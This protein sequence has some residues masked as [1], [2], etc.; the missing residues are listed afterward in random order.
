M[1]YK[2]SLIVATLGRKTELELLLKSLV[3]QTISISLFEVI[4]VDQ[5]EG[6]L[7]DGLVEKYSGPLNL[8]CIKSKR[9]GLSH[10]RNI[11]IRESRGTYIG[12]PDDD[13]EY[14]P[15][16]LQT[17]EEEL[18]KLSQPDMIIGKVFNRKT[19]TYV[20]KKTPDQPLEI[21]RSNFY[22]VVSSITLFFKKEEHTFD[23]DFGIGEKYHSNED[24][25]LILNFLKS[26]KRVVYSPA[27][28]FD[29]PPYDTSNMSLDKLYKYGIGFGALC[30]KYLSMPLLFLMAKVVAFQFL[31]MLKE[32][33]VF[34]FPNAKRRYWALKGRLRGFFI[35]EQAS[36]R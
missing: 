23:E 2:Y 36:V 8:R 30:R 22:S 31:M 13:C 21:N 9:K 25:E 20:F 7:I 5:N 28:D 1:N 27:V 14:Y 19:K 3:N 12:V 24:G 32:A 34:N 15:D 33:V 6:D 26:G 17:L 18:G 4:I 16:T 11:G 29:H 10:N 35:F